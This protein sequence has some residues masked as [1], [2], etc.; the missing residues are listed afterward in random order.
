MR[1]AG[2][3]PRPAFVQLCHAAEPRDPAVLRAHGAESFLCHDTPVAVRQIVG[4]TWQ[5]RERQRRYPAEATAY[6]S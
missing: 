3:R 1:P 6:E 5:G 4:A 2:R